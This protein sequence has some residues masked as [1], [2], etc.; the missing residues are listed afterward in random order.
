[1]K[2]YRTGIDNVQKERFY[3]KRDYAPYCT[4]Q[5]FQCD[6]KIVL[7][8]TLSVLPKNTII[9]FSP[10]SK[11]YFKSAKGPFINSFVVFSAT[12]KEQCQ[13]TFDTPIQIQ[14]TDFFYTLLRLLHE[15]F[16]S[17]TE[18]GATLDLLLKALLE[19][20]KEIFSTIPVQPRTDKEITIHNMRTEILGC[21]QFDWNIEKVAATCHMSPSRFHVV[22]KQK[23][24][25]S[26]MANIIQN[27]IIIAQSLLRTTDKAIHEIAENCGYRSVA[28]FSRQFKKM[29]GSTPTEFRKKL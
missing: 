18:H 4:F 12:Q 9:L 2:I 24:G 1:M 5:L 16:H 21:A 23:Y 14:N 20:T 26:P 6:T 28:H 29:T 19:K 7:N 15:E 17:G 3:T 11:Q 22:Y 10:A 27:R 13:L 25:I 8:G